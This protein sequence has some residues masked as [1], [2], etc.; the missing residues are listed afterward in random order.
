MSLPVRRSPS[1]AETWRPLRELD[2]LHAQMDRL[3]QSAL[4]GWRWADDRAWMPAADVTETSDHYVVEVELPGVRREDVD[5]ELAGDELVITGEFKERKREGLLRRRT[6]R[7]GKFEYRVTVPGE[8]RDSDVAASLAH[9]VL[10]VELPK[11]RS[12]TA[13]KIAVT[14]SASESP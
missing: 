7:V 9:G 12:A 13:R 5:V 3:V 1:Q 2:E 8:I 11:A 6:R 10:T 14:E 4:D